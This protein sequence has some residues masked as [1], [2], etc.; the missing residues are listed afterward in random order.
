VS[1]GKSGQAAQPTGGGT[2]AT[3][4]AAFFK[5]AQ[6]SSVQPRLRGVNGTCEFNFEGAGR[7]RVTV[8]DGVATVTEGGVGTPA[9][10][11]ITC[12]ARDFQRILHREGNMNMNTAVLQGLVTATGDIPLALTLVGS[13]VPEPAG[14]P[15]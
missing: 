8:K 6:S 10:S 2:A 12:A 14:S 11:V 15:S 4:I 13:F 5:Q 7:W 9:D 3:E 1:T